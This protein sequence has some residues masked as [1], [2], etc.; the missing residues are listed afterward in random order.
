[1][2]PSLQKTTGPCIILAGAGTGKTY[3]IIEKLKYLITKEIYGPEEIV[4]L[5]FSNEAVES[6]KRR[7]NTA[8]QSE[9]KPLIRTFHSFCADLLRE[10]APK[11]NLKTDFK[12]LIPD[13]AKIMLHKYFKIHP[14]LCH[15]YIETISIAKDLGISP[16]AL[17]AFVQ[18]KQSE[19]KTPSLEKALEELK[20]DF[21]T[22]YLKSKSN[23]QEQTA[24]KEK[25]KELDSL[26]KI[27]KFIQ[28]W[29]GYEK[30]KE[31]KNCIDYADL[32]QKAIT[33]LE[34]N[35]SI[36]EAYKYII[37]DEFQD[38]NKMQCDLLVHLCPSKNITIVGDLNQSIYRFRGAYKENFANFKKSFDVKPEDIVSLDKSYRSTN[39]I[40]R[41][42][43][44]LIEKNY[45]NKEEC[46]P[47]LSVFETEGSQV[48]VL[49]LKNEKEEIR[50]II[51]HIEEEH[52]EREYEDIAVLFRTHQQALRLKKALE[53]KEIPFIAVTKNSLFATP[54]IKKAINYLVLARALAEKKNGEERAWWEIM[55]SYDF[56]PEELAEMGRELKKNADAPCLTEV[57]LAGLPLKEFT[58]EGILK[59]EKIKKN[60]QEIAL[61]TKNPIIELCEKV[62]EILAK[63]P[64][65]TMDSKANMAKYMEKV[66]EF[67]KQESD[68][69]EDFLYHLE[70]ME[71]L[72]IDVEAP[73]IEQRGVRIMTHHATKGLEY[74]H[75]I[76][77][78]MVQNK[79]P[80]ERIRSN[81]LIPSE[82]MPDLAQQLID[83]PPYAH[84]DLI[85]EYERD[86][87]LAEER[88]L[89][90]VAF[91][92]AKQKLLITFAQE[93]GARSFVPSQFLEDIQY[94]TN[95]DILFKQDL[96][97]KIR[98]EAPVI[99]N[100]Y[101]KT[102]KP[103]K[104]KAF[105]PSALLLFKDCQKKYEYKYLFHMPEKEPISWEEITLG[106]FVH[107]IIDQ[108][109]KAYFTNEQSFIEA[110]RTASVKPEWNSVNLDEAIS[111]LKIFFQRNKN[112]YTQK[113]LTEI[114]LRT[115]LDEIPFEGYADRIDI[116][117]SGI[118]IIDY[119]T[120]KTPISAQH[121][122]WQLGLYALGAQ[123]LGLG[124]VKKLTLDM[125]RFEKPVEF[126]L[127]D[128][129]TARE[130]YSKRITFN[131]EEVKKELITTAK[132]IISCY[133]KGFR[134]CPPEKGCEF[135]SEFV[136]KE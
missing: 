79:F 131:L 88:R 66:K 6:L 80:A 53:E 118:E 3:T 35:P 126:E 27:Q 52:K 28:A 25:I 84:E 58:A 127:L 97:E 107:E 48:E 17:Q 61:L 75:V 34:K 117:P 83:T 103:T 1:M 23:R 124:K 130:V 87:Q 76:C 60:V 134:A 111:L 114:K 82:L 9:N 2:H 30:I 38:T 89:A 72:G 85:E 128:D 133:E 81:G 10:N 92:R 16:E 70:V 33:L 95:E 50:A 110:A 96:K 7:F 102:V 47:V 31:K 54:T 69:L 56:E 123:N 18:K 91:T 73:A 94:K 121:R 21:N 62:G 36:A 112:K 15:R 19:Q 14:Q 93:Y 71:K 32:N 132:E 67:S 100:A 115:V 63:E 105:S 59:A 40:L 12:I 22:A 26:L 41:T 51:E 136:W 20:L 37:V 39:K 120:G 13:E 64:D 109:I 129:G 44:R 68:R 43:H 113:S 57:I 101:Q 99:E 106:S 86:N 5:T 4:C 119:K 74:G 116:M 65:Y 104:K 49:E 55:H 46:F 125:L 8:L 108:G 45:K 29:R 90:Y 122:N 42:A 77:T 135:C 24:K 98:D 11:I 78:N